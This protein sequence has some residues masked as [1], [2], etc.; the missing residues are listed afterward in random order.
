MK[1]HL[2]KDFTPILNETASN[3]LVFLWTKRKLN[4]LVGKTIGNSGEFREGQSSR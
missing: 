1:R 4:S 2:D 3:G